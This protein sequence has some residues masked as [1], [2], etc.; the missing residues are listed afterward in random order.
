LSCAMSSA[1]FSASMS[2]A[3]P[4][5]AESMP[6]IESQIEAD[7]SQKRRLSAIILHALGERYD[8]DCASQF[9]RATTLVDT[10]T[11]HDDPP[12]D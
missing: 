3:V 10:P 7:D 8:A 12:S 4:S 9:R 2:F 1:A 11:F 6:P 5:R